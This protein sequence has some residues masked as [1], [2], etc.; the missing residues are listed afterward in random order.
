MLGLRTEGLEPGKY[1]RA[2]KVEKNNH[3]SGVAKD[4]PTKPGCSRK[5]LGAHNVLLGFASSTL[6]DPQS[7]WLRKFDSCGPTPPPVPAHRLR[8]RA[9]PY[10][11]SRRICGVRQVRRR[12]SG[13]VQERG[14]QPASRK[15]RGVK[16]GTLS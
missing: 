2:K 5:I 15:V 10:L 12:D 16:V 13:A 3:N 7:T 9:L 14:T 1:W 8:L 4:N 11:M 6:A